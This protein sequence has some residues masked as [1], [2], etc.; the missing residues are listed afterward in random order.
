MAFG[1]IGIAGKKGLERSIWGFGAASALSLPDFEQ[2]FSGE[3]TANG[4][5]IY[6]GGLAFAP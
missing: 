4:W 2:E 1:G 6:A 3:M 5:Q